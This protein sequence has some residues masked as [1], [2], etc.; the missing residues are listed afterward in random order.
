MELR[1]DDPLSCVYVDLNTMTMMLHDGSFVPIT[2]LLD[3]EGDECGPDDALVAVA[4]S[5]AR[6]WWT[7]PLTG[8][9]ET[10]N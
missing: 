8:L 1:P 3:D 2:I 6:G 5:D 7:V 9:G 4:G 10:L